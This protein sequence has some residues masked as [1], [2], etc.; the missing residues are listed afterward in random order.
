MLFTAR[1]VGQQQLIMWS[2]LP[3]GLRFH[4]VGGG[5]PTRQRGGVPHFCVVESNGVALY[6]AAVCES[7]RQDGVM[8]GKYINLT[9]LEL[10]RGP[11][12]PHYM[13]STQILEATCLPD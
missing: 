4:G 8:I 13:S 10:V 11:R 7:G 3:G 12:F 1:V 9:Q 5:S 2:D 6:V